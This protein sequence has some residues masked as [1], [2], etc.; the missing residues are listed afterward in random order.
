M[1]A[2]NTITKEVIPFC[3]KTSIN[4]ESILSLLDKVVKA[5]SRKDVAITLVMDNARYQRNSKV[6]AY[7]ESLGVELL[8]LPSYSPNL[9]LIERLW[10]FVKKECLYGKY[11]ATFDEFTTVTET[12]LSETVTTHKNKLSTLLSLKFQLFENV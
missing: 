12:C 10:K 5:A 7:A 9:N 8:F 6:M 11:Y 2:L 1:G 4:T 3:N